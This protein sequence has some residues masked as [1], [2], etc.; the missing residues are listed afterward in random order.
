MSYFVTSSNGALRVCS[1]LQ[2][3]PPLVVVVLAHSP[4]PGLAIAAFLMA[5]MVGTWPARPALQRNV[6]HDVA[7]LLEPGVVSDTVVGPDGLRLSITVLDGASF[8]PVLVAVP[9]SA[10]YLIRAVLDSAIVELHG[11]CLPLDLRPVY[12]HFTAIPIYR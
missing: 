9:L 2:R 11:F 10:L 6:L 7:I 3:H 8:R 1:T 4:R 5:V 12:Y